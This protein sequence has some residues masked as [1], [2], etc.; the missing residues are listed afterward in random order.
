MIGLDAIDREG[1]VFTNPPD[2]SAVLFVMVSSAKR[3]YIVADHT[4]IRKTTLRCFGQLGEWTGVITDE[5]CDRS[6][7]GRLQELNVHVSIA[8]TG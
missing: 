1:K 4:K 3:V 8:P 7:I 6:F 2:N 5:G